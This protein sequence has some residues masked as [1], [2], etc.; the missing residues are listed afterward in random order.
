MAFTG[1]SAAPAFSAAAFRRL[2]WSGAVQARIVADH[3]ARADGGFQIGRHA[4]FDEVAPLEQLTVGLGG[5]LQGVTAVAE[6]RRLFAQHHGR[7][8]PNR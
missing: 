3:L 6:H 8:R 4:T 5:E 2:S 1:F 7:P